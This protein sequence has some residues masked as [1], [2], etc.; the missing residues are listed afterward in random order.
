[1]I[2]VRL[3]GAEDVETLAR[4][5]HAIDLHYWSAAAP[6]PTFVAHVRDRVLPSGC[7]VAIAEEGGAALGIATFAVLFPAP[8]FGGSLF[9][10]D[11]FTVQEA[12]GRGVGHVL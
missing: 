8:A 9:L 5:F 4:L 11:L 3:A 12:R 1:M 6:L 10:K 7:E 2:E